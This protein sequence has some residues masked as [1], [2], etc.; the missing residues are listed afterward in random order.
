LVELGQRIGAKFSRKKPTD[1][2]SGATTPA[3]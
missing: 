2:A 3:E 1:P